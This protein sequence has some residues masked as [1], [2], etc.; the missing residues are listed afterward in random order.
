MKLNELPMTK[1]GQKFS[2]FENV[3]AVGA[4]NVY[5]YFKT[6]PGGVSTS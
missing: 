6:G 2:F 4:G 1:L 3:I 5:L